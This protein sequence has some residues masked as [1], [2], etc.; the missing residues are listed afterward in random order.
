MNT[1]SNNLEGDIKVTCNYLGRS[2]FD[3]HVY[4]TMPVLSINITSC[5]WLVLITN[6]YMQHSDT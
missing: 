6:V 3:R 5:M 1:F 4:L 2:G